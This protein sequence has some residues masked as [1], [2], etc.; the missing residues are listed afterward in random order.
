MESTG[1]GTVILDGWTEFPGHARPGGKLQ[2]GLARAEN[3]YLRNRY[4]ATTETVVVL[5]H[6]PHDGDR[7]SVP[8]H[9]RSLITGACIALGGASSIHRRES[10][11]TVTISKDRPAAVRRTSHPRTSGASSSKGGPSSRGWGCR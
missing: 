4:E 10:N 8:R 7:A 5:H 11:A 2:L 6:V 1:A 3:L 9:F